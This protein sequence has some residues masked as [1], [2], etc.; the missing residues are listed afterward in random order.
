[1]SNALAKY[2]R[3][4][5]FYNR[6]LSWIDFNDRVLEEA[7]DKNNPLL[8]RVKFLAITQSNLDE[9]IS[10]RVATLAKMDAVGYEKPDPSGMT[11]KD[12]L[13]AISAKLHPQVDK[14]YTTLSRSL[15]P[16][17]RQENIR[18]LSAE[19]LS[20]KQRDY[21]DD[22]F[23]QE[24]YPVLT[25]LA[26]DASRPFPF[27]AN[28]TINLAIMLMHPDEKDDK[29]ARSFAMVQVPRVFSRVLKLP[30]AE[31]DFILLEDVIKL[32]VNELFIGSDIKEVA[33]FRVIR[34]MDIDVEDEDTSDLMKEIQTQLKQRE[35]GKA[36]KMEIEGSASKYI[37]KQLSKPLKLKDED[38]YQLNGPIDLTFLSKLVKQVDNKENLLYP[39]F[40]P[41]YPVYLHGKNMFDE[42]AKHDIFLNHPYDS[43]E[44]V[45]DFIAQGA[46][47]P[48]VLAIKMT[49]YRVSA[50]S[51]IIAH[52]KKAAENG[53]QV[54]VLVELKARFDEQNNVHWAKE[55]EKAG[56]HV[57]YGLI[58][59][60]THCKLALIVRREDTGIKRYMHMAT[61]NYNDVTA[62]AYTD[63]AL[64]TA[65][66][67][68]GIDATN[69]FN[70]L[71]GFSKPPYFHKLVIS[72]EGIRDF[73]CDQ[74]DQEIKNVKAGKQ[75]FIQMKMN[76]LS[77]SV[78]IEKMYQASQAGVKINLLIRGIC[79]LKVGV[80]GLSENITVHSIVGRFLEHSRIYYFYADGE[81]RVYLS[82]ADLMKRNLSRRVEL[83]FPI[84]QEN[85]QKQV[86]RIYNLMWADNIKTRVMQPDGTYVKVD[87]RGLAPLDVQE[88]LLDHAK[89]IDDILV[90]PDE[91]SAQETFQSEE[92]FFPLT[93]PHN[94]LGDDK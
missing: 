2:N 58:G 48:E 55:L 78:M 75:G 24:L 66:E 25:P 28:D 86:I 11:A 39:P 90:E 57:I 59:L 89:S 52:L 43:F 67:E 69:I 81:E 80:K 3:P 8:E 64:F 26:V 82:S 40:T 62:K 38:I 18:L 54:T 12:Q 19:D 22:Y 47:D 76:S 61:G 36:L 70:M 42:I 73:L 68:M 93:K 53:K 30:A 27:I 5:N 9:F 32:F 84:L 15:A 63:M 65:N 77:D 21:V 92:R 23:H 6:E 51:P 20:H 85:I 7:R 13:R 79:N 16:K 29:K 34:D 44:P 35:H 87:R 49:L 41:Y 88:Y 17:L 4:Q 1:M 72:P 91:K 71:S 74:I 56:C 14:Q 60:K 83:L 33:V 45:T 46:E 10:V 37:K 50:Q 94:M 31:N